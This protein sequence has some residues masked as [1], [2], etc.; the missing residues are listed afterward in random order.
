MQAEKNI[1][2]K[3]H[4]VT[5]IPADT[6]M[7]CVVESVVSE[8]AKKKRNIQGLILTIKSDKIL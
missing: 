5:E 4:S 2:W 8:K 7:N 6:F 1:C 3:F